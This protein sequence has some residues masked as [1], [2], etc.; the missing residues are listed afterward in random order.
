MAVSAGRHLRHPHR[1]TLRQTQTSTG[2]G[3][4]RALM[5]ADPKTSRV[6]YRP[7]RGR[8]GRV[9]RDDFHPRTKRRR[10]QVLQDSAMP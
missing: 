6:V 10:L 2:D 1:R 8:I 7:D 9:D 5:N 3:S 4:R